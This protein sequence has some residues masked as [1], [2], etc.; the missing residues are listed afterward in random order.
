[1]LK[2]GFK[3]EAERIAADVRAELDLGPMDP[4]NPFL[5]AEHLAIPVYGMREISKITPNSSFVS[6]FS[7]DD[8]ESFSAVTVFVGMRRFIVHNESHHTHRQASNVSHE[9]SHTLL[10]HGP[11][12]VLRADGDRFWNSD[13]EDEASWLG[14]AL[15]VPRDG[16]LALAKRNWTVDR[17]ASHYSVSE[18]LAQWRIDQTG[19]PY[20]IER[21]R[22]YRRGAN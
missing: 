14:A 22:A 9:I 10:E 15:S 17:I 20:Q 21:L 6:F 1:M 11:T 16:A 13:V 7:F 12:P 3:A 4:L 2:R 5:V 18:K 8:Q 19:I